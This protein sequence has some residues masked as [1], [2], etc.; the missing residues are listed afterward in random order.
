[1]SE[2]KNSTRILSLDELK[3]Y[4]EDNID[5]YI[6]YRNNI[7]AN[8]NK[9]KIGKEPRSPNFPEHISEP[10]VAYIIKKKEKEECVPSQYGDLYKPDINAKIEVKAFSSDGPISFGSTENWNQIYF[11][12]LRKLKCIDTGEIICH[13]L[14]ISNKE[15]EWRDMK[16]TKSKTFENACEK[17][18]HGVPTRPRIGFKFL[19]RQ[20]IWKKSKEIFRGT[21]KELFR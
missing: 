15:V 17:S 14:S 13:K 16:I 10:L 7:L 2:N 9:Y 20:E 1:M 3:L 5:L 4:I 8:W 11:L 12:D 18:L 19:E 21:I 6:N